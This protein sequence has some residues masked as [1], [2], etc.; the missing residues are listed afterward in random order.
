MSL[1]SNDDVTEFIS[2]RKWS[3]LKIFLLRNRSLVKL[4][5]SYRT[6]PQSSYNLLHVVCENNPPLHIVKFIRRRHPQAV[7]EKDDNGHFPLH[8]AC[9]SGCCPEVIKYLLD[10]NSE[11][12]MKTDDK[13]RTP[14][15]LAYKCYAHNCEKDW[16]P[17]NQDLYEVA[18][19][20]SAFDSS[21]FFLK[22]YEGNTAL[23]FAVN[24]MLSPALVSLVKSLRGFEDTSEFE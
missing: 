18:S 19:M 21:S 17:A 7:F 8:I 13:K 5:R 23:E 24:G 14:F 4:Q 15:L 9:K 1:T 10:K 12:A 22:D 20:L 16:I 11:A 6:D 2:A 3:T